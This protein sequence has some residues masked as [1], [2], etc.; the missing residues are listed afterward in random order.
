MERYGRGATIFKANWAW[1]P[2]A[3]GVTVEL[4]DA[5]VAKPTFTAP[6]V[7]GDLIFALTVNDGASSSAPDTIKVSVASGSQVLAGAQVDGGFS[8]TLALKAD[9][10]LW[11]FGLGGSGEL[12]TGTTTKANSPVQVCEVYDVPGAN[13]TTF[14]TGVKVV[15]LEPRWMEASAIPSR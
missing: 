11:A 1:V 2:W 14:F 8:H 4:S 5:S 9:G 7:A 13:C 10:S 15:Q 12:G 3:S 6:S